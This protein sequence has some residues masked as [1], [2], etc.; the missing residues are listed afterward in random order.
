MRRS[1]PQSRP[2]RLQGR[3]APPAAAP[4]PTECPLSFWSLVRNAALILMGYR[5]V[6]FAHD[7][8]AAD[9]RAPSRVCNHRNDDDSCTCMPARN[10]AASSPFKTPKLP[11]LKVLT[12][13]NPVLNWSAS[14][15]DSTCCACSQPYAATP[16]PSEAWPSTWHD[17]LAPI[18]RQPCS[19]TCC[20][21]GW[22][23]QDDVHAALKFAPAPA[24]DAGVPPEPG[25]GSGPR[26][27]RP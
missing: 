22:F 9:V 24:E 15:A 25:P 14:Y 1:A 20:R 17:P 26:P 21:H 2:G 4:L 5:N 18:C 27:L 12:P 6:I 13:R 11:K 7:A 3:P 10:G 16:A 8:K 19:V 23:R